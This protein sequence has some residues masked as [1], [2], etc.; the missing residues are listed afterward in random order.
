MTSIPQV[1]FVNLSRELGYLFWV[2][3]KSWK[4]IVPDNFSASH[5]LDMVKHKLRVASFELRV[6]SLKVRVDSLK[7][8]VKIQK[9]EFKFTSYEFKSTSYEF[10]STSYEFK[11]TS[12]EFKFKSYR[13]KSW[14]SRIIK[15]TKT[16]VN[17]L[18]FFTGNKKIRSDFINFASQR[19]FK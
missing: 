17:S 3:G 16:Q 7:A 2:V 15:S 5:K 8:R 9:C 13:F 10:K 18:H 14:S 4:N 1:R 6:E 12:Y 11:S 19:N